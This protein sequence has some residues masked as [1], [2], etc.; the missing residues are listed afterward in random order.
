M[1]GGKLLFTGQMRYVGNCHQDDAVFSGLVRGEP[2]RVNGKTIHELKEEGVFGL[3]NPLMK[4]IGVGDQVWW[5]QWRSC[6]P[7]SQPIL[8]EGV[9]ESIEEQDAVVITDAGES[10]QI[11]TNMLSL[12]GEADEFYQ[13]LKSRTAAAEEKK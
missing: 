11:Y 7:G 10:I 12:A 8:H 5:P 4:A 2:G 13:S 9:V 1:F 3:Y 6:A